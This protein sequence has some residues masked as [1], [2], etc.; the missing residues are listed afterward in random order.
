MTAVTEDAVTPTASRIRM[1][2]IWRIVRLH[3]IKPSVFFGVPLLI[4]GGAWVI[5][6]IVTGLIAAGTGEAVTFD[7]SVGQRYSWAVISP[8]WY[9]VVVGVQ[10]IAYTFSFALGFGSTRRNYWLGTALMFTLTSAVFALLIACLVQIEKAT[11]GWFIGAHMFDTLWYGI[12]GFG[13]DFYTTFS[14]Q[15]FVLFIGAGVTAVFMRWRVR[16][17]LVLM[18]S[19]IAVL[20]AVA[21][22]LTFT[23]TWP[24]L[25][26]WLASLGI[27]GTFTAVLLLALASGVSGYAV[28][29]KATP[30]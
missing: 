5:T 25:F 15:L 20:L 4:L 18:F 24:E 14:L 9:L 30:R 22:V 13:V 2:D 27:V 6:L 16:G 26:A 23:N 28:I 10:A 17:M 7:A 19:F 11:S 12:D 21:T 3:C 1:P 29:R 8:Q